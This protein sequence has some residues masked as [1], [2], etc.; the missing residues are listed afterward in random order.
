M[1]LGLVVWWRLS[2]RSELAEGLVVARAVVV[3]GD[4]LAR[5]AGDRFPLDGQGGLVLA[6][7]WRHRR[8]GRTPALR[9]RLLVR[10]RGAAH[11]DVE[12]DHQAVEGLALRRQLLAD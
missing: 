6:R 11:H 9:G 2:R 4:G 8:L 5:G 12:P 1:V 10:G 3:E 7:R